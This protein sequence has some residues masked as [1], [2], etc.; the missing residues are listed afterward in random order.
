LKVEQILKIFARRGFRGSGVR[1]GSIVCGIVS[2]L[3]RQG[4]DSQHQAKRDSHQPH[5][6]CGLPGTGPQNRKAR[7]HMI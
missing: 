7:D 2:I 4:G 5:C 1:I 6:S 3:S